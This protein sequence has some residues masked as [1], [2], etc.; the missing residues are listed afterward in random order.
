MADLRFSD[1]DGLPVRQRRVTGPSEAEKKA[2]AVCRAKFDAMKRSFEKHRKNDSDDLRRML[3]G[4]HLA[5]AAGTGGGSTVLLSNGDRVA[6]G[7]GARRTH[8]NLFLR[9]QMGLKG[10][11]VT[12]RW[13]TRYDGGDLPTEI[14][15][16]IESFH[17]RLVIEADVPR[18]FAD[19]LDDGGT[20][21]PMVI[22]Y[23]ID[24]KA[25]NRNK[26][27]ASSAPINEIVTAVAN[28]QPGEDEY[29]PEPG[30]DL[31]AL[32]SSL[33]A[34]AGDADQAMNR[35]IEQL[36]NLERVAKEADEL[37]LDEMDAMPSGYAYGGIQAQRL[38]YGEDCWWDSRVV[39]S[40][41]D[42]TCFA[43]RIIYSLS[44][45]KKEPAFKKSAVDKLT[46]VAG[47][48][49]DGWTSMTASGLSEEETKAL[50]DNVPVIEF[51]DRET[52]LVHYFTETAGYEGFLEKDPTY[53]Y[54]DAKGQ[55][56][57]K[58]WFPMRACVAVVDNLRRN[59]RTFGKPWLEA[60]KDHAI[61]YVLFDTALTNSR[62]KAGRIVEYPDDLPNDV[63][64]IIEDGGDLALVP[65]PAEIGESKPLIYVHEF[66]KSPVDFEAAKQSAL[67]SFARSVDMSV[68]EISGVS[69]A[70]T[71]GQAE[72][73]AS[74]TRGSKGGL[75]RKLQGFAGEVTRDIGALA[76]A[77][78]TEERVTAM[79][80]DAFTK[81]FPVPDAMDPTKQAM[82]PDT[83][84]PALTPSIWDLFRNSSMAGDS[85]EVVFSAANDD[86]MR[87]KSQMDFLVAITGPAGMNPATGLPYKDP[88]PIIDKLAKS[89][90]FGELKDFPQSTSSPG[91]G[92]E[93]EDGDGEDGDEEKPPGSG[94]AD[95]RHAGG[96]RGPAP[97]PGRQGR[98]EGPG[99]VGDFSTK[100]NRV[101]TQ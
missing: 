53:P 46:G 51:W 82:N 14:T 25:I 88:R 83:G 89:M 67:Y 77:F 70:P 97:V 66:G 2:V 92:K 86:L 32:S 18:Q 26:M 38:V 6:G 45:I 96:G 11:T 68:E 100:V 69:I 95:D 43:R 4:K 15:D 21:G 75:I 98:G 63:K 57:F 19:A 94:S 34:F 64:Q 91:K 27:S 71:V 58:D 93:G 33:R 36:D 74:G 31:Q 72:M 79:M 54:R 39:T 20:I 60:G 3:A 62:S 12:D 56:I 59:D 23:G 17:E 40:W 52:G 90:G 99:D 49:A 42:A 84:E 101:A 28:W 16:E 13:S 81:R 9:A 8:T 5:P 73:A 76:K 37:W 24:R 65:R 50:N 35:T 61:Q 85:I 22:Y 78:Y 55:S 80:G 41:H 47:Q 30:M 87:A 7:G 48:E 1:K 10:A 29:H 44:N